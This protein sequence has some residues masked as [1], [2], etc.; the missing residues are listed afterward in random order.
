MND[1]VLSDKQLQDKSALIEQLGATDAQAVLLVTTVDEV[2]SRHEALT[3]VVKV[4]S[5][6]SAQK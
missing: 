3:D 4:L 2:V 5:V 6:I 1:K